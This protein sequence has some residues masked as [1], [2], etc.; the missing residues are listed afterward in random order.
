[1]I[2]QSLPPDVRA[3]V[4]TRLIERIVANDERVPLLDYDSVKRFARTDIAPTIKQ[5]WPIHKSHPEARDLLLR[6]DLARGVE[7][8]HRHR[9]G[10]RSPKSRRPARTH[11]RWPCLYGDG[12]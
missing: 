10:S 1:M 12:R 5:L 7:A 11:C 6:L 4:L 8:M 9:R 2:P 3:N